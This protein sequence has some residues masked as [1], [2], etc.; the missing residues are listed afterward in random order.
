VPLSPLQNTPDNVSVTV[1]LEA[2]DS[3]PVWLNFD[4]DTLTLSG[5][6][7]ATATGKTYRLT[8]RAHTADGLEGRLELTL[9]MIARMSMLRN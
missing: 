1:T 5:I 9:T 6:A 8:F 7:P 3:M 2:S 4:P